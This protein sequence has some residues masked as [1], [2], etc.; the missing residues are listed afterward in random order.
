MPG[1]R[2]LWDSNV[3]LGFLAGSEEVREAC[4]LIIEQARQGNLEI[5]VSTLAQAEVAYLQGVEPAETEARIREFFG[6]AYVI[7]AAFDIPVATVARTLIRLEWQQ[8][9]RLKP[10]DAVHLATAQQ[11]KIPVLETTDGDLLRLDGLYGTP[12]IQVRR[13]V[14]EGQQPFSG[15]GP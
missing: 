6:R 9:R 11:W 3:V 7:P 14:F 5:V 15:L 4:T 13:P 2:R 8:G 1:P 10:P 12:V